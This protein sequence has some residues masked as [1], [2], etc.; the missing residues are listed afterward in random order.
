MCA[1]QRRLPF[2]DH[3]T[4]PGF[5][6]VAGSHQKPLNYRV[7]RASRS[8]IAAL[9]IASLSALSSPASWAA[10]PPAGQVKTEN[11]TPAGEGS[12]DG[13][14]KPAVP[15][16]V[17]GVMTR[18]VSTPTGT[19]YQ[20]AAGITVAAYWHQLAAP[21]VSATV[22]AVTDD[23]GR[24][25]LNLPAY[26]AESGGH[27]FTGSPGQRLRAWPLL[28]T[29]PDN[30]RVLAASGLGRLHDSAQATGAQWRGGQVD[31]LNFQ[32]GQNH[33]NL[34]LPTPPM[35]APVTPAPVTPT[36]GTPT[37][38]T[39][40]SGQPVVPV[41]PHSEVT[42]VEGRINWAIDATG[43][44]PASNVR[45][46]LRAKYMDL[47]VVA[48]T[49]ITTPGD[50]QPPQAPT[51]HEHVA[52]VTTD[53][54]G[55]Y[56]L[57][58]PKTVAIGPP[59]T[60][61]QLTVTPTGRTPIESREV[62]LVNGVVTANVLLDAS[63][64][65]KLEV[66]TTG[67]DSQSGNSAQVTAKVS[68]LPPLAGP[69][70][71]QLTDNN[72]QVVGRCDGMTADND[73]RLTDCT[74]S[75]PINTNGLQA[76]LR[77]K[78]GQVVAQQSADT[79][80]LRPG[81]DTNIPAGAVGQTYKSATGNDVFLA[82][83]GGQ[84][85]Y[86]YSVKG[87]TAGLTLDA[88]TGQLA[89]TP[90][91]TGD[92]QFTWQVTDAKGTKAEAT[93]TLR[94]VDDSRLIITKS[95]ALQRTRV[96]ESFSAAG[97]E[98]AGG[99]GANEYQ[100]SGLPSGL[101]VDKTTGQISGT[102]DR[103]G[104]FTITWTITDGANNSVMATQVITVDPAAAPLTWK[105]RS[106]P[107]L[108]AGE[109]VA[110]V[111]F[112]ASGGVQPYS[113]SATNLPAGLTIDP[114]TGAISGT[115]QN[116]GEVEIS[117]KVVDSATQENSKNIK[118]QIVSADAEPSLVFADV[119]TASQGLPFVIQSPALTGVKGPVVFTAKSL[120]QGLSIDA[121]TGKIDGTP[122]ESGQYTIAVTAL[123]GMGKS[124]STTFD[125]TVKPA[126]PEL[127]VTLA[128]KTTLD[129]GTAIDHD[130]TATG[131]D[132]SYRFQA[133][134]LPPGLALDADT[135][136]ITGTPQTAGQY[137]VTVTAI[138]SKDRRGWLTFTY[139]VTGT[140]K[141]L[142]VQV[143]DSQSANIVQSRQV[144]LQ[145]L[146]ME[147]GQAPYQVSAKGLPE[148]LSIDADGRL[149]GTTNTAGAYPV[150][151]TVSDSADQE[152]K[153]TAVVQV[154]KSAQQLVV[155]GP[156][157]DAIARVGESFVGEPPTVSGGI[158]PLSFAGSDLPD[159]LTL[160][161]ATG[162]VT[163]TPSTM[164]VF[165][166]ELT[167][168]D[169]TGAETSI[170]RSMVIKPAAG[171]TLTVNG[172]PQELPLAV[173]EEVSTNVFQSLNFQHAVGELSCS[174]KGL[175]EG[176]SVVSQ[177]GRFV[178]ASTQ[179][180]RHETSVSCVD[181][182]QQRVDFETVVVVK[183]PA[184]NVP[185]ALQQ[186][187]VGAKVETLSF[188]VNNS[189]EG[190]EWGYTAKGLPPGMS[191]DPQTGVVTGVAPDNPGSY[192]VT[193]TAT[194]G[195]QTSV[196]EAAGAAR[197]VKRVRQ[198]TK[199]QWKPITSTFS[200]TVVK[201][202]AT[203]RTQTVVGMPRSV[204]QNGV[205]QNNLPQSSAPQGV[206]RPRAVSPVTSGYRNA[207]SSPRTS[208]YPKT[209]RPLTQPHLAAVNMG[210]LGAKVLGAHNVQAQT[211]RIYSAGQPKIN[212][213]PVQASNGRAGVPIQQ[214]SSNSF[215]ARFGNAASGSM[216]RWTSKP[217]ESPTPS[218]GVVY[219]WLVVAMGGSL[220]FYRRQQRKRAAAVRNIKVK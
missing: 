62:R 29:L 14:Q 37:P 100:V 122:A 51:I 124:V 132:E 196:A 202:S 44:Q 106:T 173:G 46:E 77:D 96:G 50:Q 158:A 10:E 19:M 59:G 127:N 121:L 119:S 195:K 157:S 185:A 128:E 208:T 63:I 213:V 95:P 20:P 22:T 43:V 187:V 1:D 177:T 164:G 56:Q 209:T 205:P 219:A 142:E 156:Q 151:L 23:Q 65:T 85:P 99:S 139:T 189:P 167:V 109:P 9:A 114:A 186:I 86:T 97:P 201:Q 116:P 30:E 182:A 172:A 113:Y 42:K 110:G 26:T 179:A 4:L 11:E 188:A 39:P 15:G 199:I 94:V 143:V 220:W 129:V 217:A 53:D 153:I 17:S 163:G 178:G 34:A 200:L 74:A 194:P 21:G 149:S 170:S 144:D 174:G 7:N 134:G 203:N 176:M 131:G 162:A 3:T 24:Y 69:Y 35:P 150:T 137:Q 207:P 141:S 13:E 133:E 126:S 198:S 118:L 155:A 184:L 180:G 104:D 108:T 214:A 212:T 161:S 171:K 12:A 136:K 107:M 140:G 57:T 27:K 105:V 102:A 192:S 88:A 82:A 145:F 6:E 16:Q 48:P 28:S 112:T 159:G 64:E 45:V 36:Q 89:G 40:G 2:S 120:P 101:T 165:T 47:P 18:L 80:K 67:P 58:L 92:A 87:D 115:P 78:T 49:P 25:T 166:Y 103:A 111:A 90:Q 33:S 190:V 79:H 66:Q 72:R 52:E 125:L 152:T 181:Q 55:R 98:V 117:V 193:V 93:I 130:V 138:D 84:A 61:L 81:F 73:G 210:Y 32:I 91:K 135:G 169:S 147:G 8:L 83:L 123:N 41:T 183:A 54:Q 204:P 76:I 168:S 71:L 70:S 38:V 31:Q 5:Q 206:S 154:K 68:G 148:G 197:V 215:L 160:D 218:V 75:A 216:S 211:T 146:T 60:S 175:P 191:L